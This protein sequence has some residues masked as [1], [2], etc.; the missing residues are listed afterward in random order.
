VLFGIA[1]ADPVSIGV[2]AATLTTASLL[3]NLIPAVRAMRVDPMV[4]LRD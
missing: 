1:P 3:A 2:S 4:A